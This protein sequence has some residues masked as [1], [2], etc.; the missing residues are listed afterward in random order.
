ML[1]RASGLQYNVDFF[2][3]Y[4]PERVSP[5]DQVH[6]LKNIVKVTSVSNPQT[7]DLV[8]ELYV[9]IIDAGTHK[10]SSIKIAEASKA[11]ENAQRR[12]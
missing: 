6:T 8:D 10:A 5:G 3:A 1:E 12:Y 2:C 4:S 9:S 11:I 7:A